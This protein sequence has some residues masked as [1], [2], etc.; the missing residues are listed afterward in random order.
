MRKVSTL[1]GKF[2]EYHDKVADTQ[3]KTGALFRHTGGRNCHGNEGYVYFS[4]CLR[5]SAEFR[6]LSARLSI[7]RRNEKEGVQVNFTLGQYV[8][9]V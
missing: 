9:C 3:A 5:R 4:Q 2:Q 8:Q 7:D 1:Q 6:C